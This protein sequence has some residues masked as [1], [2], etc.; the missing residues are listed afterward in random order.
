MFALEKWD[1]R[2]LLKLDIISGIYITMLLFKLIFREWD[3]AKRDVNIKA[4]ATT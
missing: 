4:S 2:K 3:F 1:Y